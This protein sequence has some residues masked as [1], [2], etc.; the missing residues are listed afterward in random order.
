MNPISFRT[1]ATLQ[2]SPV[3]N[4]D[5]LP[6]FRGVFEARGRSI[7]FPRRPLVMGILNIND[8]SFSGD[9]RLDTD[10]ALERAVRMAREGADI[11]DV[12]G[13]SART[14][15]AA[16]PVEEE[17]RRVLPFL[18]SVREAWKQA[19][20][21]D[22][23]QIF[24]PLVSLNTWRPEVVEGALDAGF[25]LLNDMGALPDDTNARL[26][27]R[28]G[29]A[30]LIMHSKGEPKVGHRHVAYDDVI[31]EL[32]IFFREKTR[33]ALD[34]GVPRESLLLDPGL[35]F[36]KQ[37]EDNLRILRELP[38]IARLGFPVLL[39]VS[40]KTVIGEVLGI[41]EAAKRDAGT[42][43]CVVAGAMRGASV[44]RVHHVEA[45]WFALRALEG[46]G[47]SPRALAPRLA[48]SGCG[49]S[50]SP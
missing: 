42:I 13:E 14:N 41:R 28:I 34:A 27:A 16:V 47:A 7:D 21:R 26:C 29:A 44:F 18:E 24:P 48:K 37:R 20:P 15:R 25:D 35:D 12:G 4:K 9:G 50:F 8:D 43:A 23:H 3:E 11:I 45:A 39:P 10:W 17:L 30:L 40:R 2:E 46:M 36:A 31:E 1:A 33:M 6:G 5:N 49:G 22:G 19:E 38:H 32:E